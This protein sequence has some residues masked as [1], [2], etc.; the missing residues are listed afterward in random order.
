MEYEEN[1]WVKGF[2]GAITISD[3]QG[4]VLE[5]NDASEKVFEEDGGREIIGKNMLACH[6]GPARTKLEKMMKNQE[7]NIY[8]IEKNGRKKIIYQTPWY[9]DGKYAGFVELAFEIPFEMP[10]FLRD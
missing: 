8:T 5:I 4:I 2:P 3:T 9:K 10:H 1:A 7:T 6:P